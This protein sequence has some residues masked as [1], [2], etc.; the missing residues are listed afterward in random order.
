MLDFIQFAVTLEKC[1]PASHYSG[2][3]AIRVRCARHRVTVVGETSRQAFTYATAETVVTVDLIIVSGT[4]S[5]VE[6]FATIRWLRQRSNRE[7][8]FTRRAAVCFFEVL[9]GVQCCSGASSVLLRASDS[10][11][12]R[13]STTRSKP[14]D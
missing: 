4:N 6:R 14:L 8:V 12:E 9:R 2:R 3:S 7:K 13:L 11:L 10:G 1:F 5:D